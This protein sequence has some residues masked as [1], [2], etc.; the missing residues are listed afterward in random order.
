M[1]GAN[2]FAHAD[3]L[4]FGATEAKWLLALWTIAWALPN[5]QQLMLAHRAAL[6]TYVGEIEPL[7]R[8]W[9]AWSPRP[10]WAAGTAALALA[11]MLDLTRIREFL[12]FLF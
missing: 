9:L 11:A 3:P 12:Y 7:R 10:A 6:E 8:K 1:A 5:A 4:Y 2:G